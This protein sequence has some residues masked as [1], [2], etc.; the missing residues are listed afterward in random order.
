MVPV[1]A[2]RALERVRQQIQDQQGLAWSDST[3][4]EAIDAALEDLW[5]TI[6]LS[7]E[8]YELDRIDITADDFT[9]LDRAEVYEYALPEYVVDVRKV[10]GVRGDGA[11]GALPILKGHLEDKARA[12]SGFARGYVKWSFTKH[13]RPGTLAIFGRPAQ[14]PL[15]RVWFMRRYPPM[16]VGTAAVGGTESTILLTATA[17]RVIRRPHLYVGMDLEVTSGPDIDQI[18][19]I[20]AWDGTAATFAPALT[21]PTDAQTYALVLPL[22]PEYVEYLIQKTAWN[23]AQRAGNN[24]YIKAHASDIRRQEERFRASLTARPTHE[25]LRVWSSRQ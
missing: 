1:N 8:D 5:T 25:P 18:V 24:E 12:F 7:G 21:A 16:H 13:G 3:V 10:E 20:T 17:G 2:T 4:L 22:E 23:L 9:K 19:R 15:I 11:T 14:W 6:K